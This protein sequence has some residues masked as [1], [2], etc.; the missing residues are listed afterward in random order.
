MIAWVPT[1]ERRGVEGR[2]GDAADGAQR[3]GAQ[4]GGA[5]LEG[6]RAGRRAG[7]GVPAAT[8]A[9]K[10]TAWPKADGLAGCGDGGGGRGLV[11]RL[12][13]AAAEVLAGSWCRRRR[14]P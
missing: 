10:V 6:H 5:V 1:G 7:A 11:D 8:V 9:V 4:D 14:R 3:A 13:S 2:G 12:G